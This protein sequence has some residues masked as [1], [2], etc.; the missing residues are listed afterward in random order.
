MTSAGTQKYLFI[1]LILASFLYGCSSSSTESEIPEST[2]TTMSQERE[3]IDLIYN[4]LPQPGII[5]RRLEETGTDFDWSFL[6]IGDYPQPAGDT[7]SAILSGMLTADVSYFI[8]FDQGQFENTYYERLNM[9]SGDMC[10]IP[11]DEIQVMNHSFRENG[12]RRDSLLYFLNS[13]YKRTT[14]SLQSGNEGHL[15][16]LYT[17]SNVIENMYINASLINNYPDNL[18]AEDSRAI[19]II[20]LVRSLLEQ[21]PNLEDAILLLSQGE[22]KT[23]FTSGLKT[24][25]AQLDRNYDLLNID[26]S[27]RER[28]ADLLMAD[29]TFQQLRGKIGNI[30]E[31]LFLKAQ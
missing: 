14:E 31:M 27:L 11:R 30:R 20:P 2:E 1:S 19:I 16:I 23:A 7:S 4:R 26:G 21:E 3:E 12:N 10:G 17:I 18:L 29:T 6:N 22:D 24:E 28:R 9:L 5:S 13:I 15:A 8:A 25:L